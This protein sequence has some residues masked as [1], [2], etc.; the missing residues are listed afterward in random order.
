MYIHKLN[1]GAFHPV[2]HYIMNN[3]AMFINSNIVKNKDV[4]C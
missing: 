3:I 4:Q 1:V 2:M